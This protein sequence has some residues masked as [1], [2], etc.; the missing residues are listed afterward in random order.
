MGNP[1][2]ETAQQDAKEA[3]ENLGRADLDITTVEKM[4]WWT[5][6]E[7]PNLARS[8]KKTDF[9]IL[10]VFSATYGT[11]R[12]ITAA[13]KRFKIPAVI[14]AI[15]T[16]YSLAT[17]GLANSYLRER[18]YFVRLICN[19]P[20][21]ES[22]RSN[23]ETIARAARAAREAKNRRIGIIGSLSPLMISL[24]FNLPLLKKKLGPTTVK[25][26]L[27][28]LE[29]AL[30]SVKDSDVQNA[31]SQ[32]EEK[33]LVNVNHK[34]LEKAA[35]FQLAVSR[36]VKTKKLD[37]IALE[38]WT[39]LFTKYGVNPCLGHV[40]DLVVGCEG[41]VVSMSGSLILMSIN[42]VNPYL[43]D[44]LSVDQKRNL[45]EL[46]HCAAPISLASDPSKIKIAERT[47]AK[48]AGKTAFVNFSLK[49]GPVT[50]V[51][52]YGRQLDKIHFTFGDLK[53]TGEYWG[54]I[55]PIVE[56]RGNAAE[57]LKN[58]SGNHYLLT[59]GD[60]REELRIFAELNGLEVRED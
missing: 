37:G 21:D 42:G 17:S 9:D 60:L 16:R 3:L 15:P 52:F 24:P 12:C 48:S 30:K 31:V 33:Y 32:I 19:E 11:V 56:S 34:I 55:K 27:P 2:L 46:S 7:I 23:I 35:L 57:F 40:D 14:W 49:N 45:I 20:K 47:D 22:V 44:I 26:G 1:D 8:V 10:V 38:C 58:V 54:G 6:N 25:I 28:S 41:D 50:L 4:T 5:P 53:D 59:Y 18:G 51:R 29:K 39:N 36:I 43:A 13:A